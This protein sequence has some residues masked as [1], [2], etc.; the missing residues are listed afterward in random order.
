MCLLTRYL[1]LCHQPHVIAL[2]FQ[3]QVMTDLEGTDFGCDQS[4]S[5]SKDSEV[6][7]LTL[8]QFMCKMAEAKQISSEGEDFL[9]GCS[10]H[11]Q[12]IA[13]LSGAGDL[14]PD[15]IYT[16]THHRLWPALTL[17]MH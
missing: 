17:L 15:V 8:E 12:F 14:H 4:R 2:P 11:A 7:T 1:T 13:V 9:S 16:Q 5:F 3:A 10:Q 6:S